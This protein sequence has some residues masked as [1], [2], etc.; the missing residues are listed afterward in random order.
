MNEKITIDGNKVQIKKQ[1]Q[2]E[3][4]KCGNKE[5]DFECGN[6]G[7]ELNSTT[8]N[9][10]SLLYYTCKC[11][12]CGEKIYSTY[13]FAGNLNEEQ[14]KAIGGEVLPTDFD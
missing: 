5:M 8:I 10:L 11:K 13:L 6:G 2:W 14:F 7:N 9:G 12:D 3:C 1:G 4:P